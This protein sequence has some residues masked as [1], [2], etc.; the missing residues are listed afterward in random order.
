MQKKTSA[1]DVK[2]DMDDEDVEDEDLEDFMDW[3]SKTL[4][5]I[6][7]LCIENSFLHLSWII[8]KRNKLPCAVNIKVFYG[9]QKD[10]L[11]GHCL[12]LNV[13]WLD[14]P[15]IVHIG[16]SIWLSVENMNRCIRIR[17]GVSVVK[18]TQITVIVSCWY[19]RLRDLVCTECVKMRCGR[20]VCL[21]GD[22]NKYWKNQWFLLF[23]MCFVFFSVKAENNQK[24]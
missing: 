11:N 5:W 9:Q 6:L 8:V 1:D 14:F 24:I 23:E 10:P 17:Q 2:E 4:K 3:R 22:E 16:L 7:E 19:V 20:D 18:P 21:N 15:I 13:Q 12:Q